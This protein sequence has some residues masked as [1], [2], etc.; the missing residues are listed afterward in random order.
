[1]KLTITSLNLQAFEE[2]E[3]RS[4][5][6][7]EYLTK[8]NPDIIVFQETVFLPSVSPH[9][10]AQ[11]LNQTLGYP[12]EVSTISRLQVGIEH[13]IYREGLAILSKYP[14]SSSDTLTLKKAEGDS[15]NRILQ[16]VDIV[17]EGAIIRL[18][19]I[20]FSITDF[21]DFATPHL[22]ET[23]DILKSRNEKRILIG[24]FNLPILRRVRTYGE[25][26]IRQQQKCLTSPTLHGMKV[27]SEPITHLFQMNMRSI[28]LQ[29]QRTGCP[30]TAPSLSSLIFQ[31]LFCKLNG[32]SFA[33]HIH[34]NRSWV[35]HST[36]NLV[37][38]VA[39]KFN[40]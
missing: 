27:L 16:M 32:T 17:V 36:F 23:L 28:Q 12:F 30:I 29:Y 11:L 20:H 7:L 3:T 21:V 19:N 4:P 14:I 38:N 40:S 15:L 24:D 26:S 25:K 18:G 10:Q 1:M 22:Q 2:W 39:C 6:I 13:P 37:R 31:I 33:N 35:L 5:R 8:T 9:N 34:F